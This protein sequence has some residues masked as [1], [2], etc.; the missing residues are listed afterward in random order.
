MEGLRVGVIA[1][2]K[3]GSLAAALTRRGAT[4]QWAPTLEPDVAADQDQ[5]RAETDAV[6]ADPPDRMVVSTGV[7][8]T[9]WLHAADRQGRGDAVRGLLRSVPVCARGP[10]AVAALRDLGVVPA[11]VSPQ[12]TDGDIVGWLADR[13]RLGQV[14]AVQV[15]GDRGAAQPYRRLQGAGVRLRTV[16]PYR[17]GPPR[18]PAPARRLIGDAIAG[19]IDVV[20]ATSAP[21]VHGLFALA[22]SEGCRDEL[23]AS[24]RGAVAAVGPVTARAFE[25]EGVPVVLVP[26]RPRT[27]D[28]LRD[29]AA[30]SRRQ[31]RAA[32]PGLVLLPGRRAVR[33][34]EREMRFGEREFAVLSALVRRPQVVCPL[35]LLARE[36]W[37]HA[38]V[39]DPRVRDHVARIR[40][41]LGP[42]GAAIVTVRSVGYRYDP[43]LVPPPPP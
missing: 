1:A 15:H 28:L 41:K 13:M 42:A 40:L 37:G 22:D 19:R 2:R 25:V 4:V 11:F 5:L 39:R 32:A 31:E 21:T 27:G 29:L 20:V 12:E 16:A 7:G 9:A 17:Y 26:R 43:S 34:V 38:P 8:L 24:L 3:G 14:L 30:W 18:D 10:K 35:E 23:A 33:V 36:A 6:L